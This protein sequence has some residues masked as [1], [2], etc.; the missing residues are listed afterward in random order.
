MKTN[1]KISIVLVIRRFFAVFVFFS[2]AFGIVDDFLSG[3]FTGDSV[4]GAIVGLVVVYFLSRTPKS[5]RTANKEDVI[6]EN[7]EK[8]E[9]IYDEETLEEFKQFDTESKNTIKDTQDKNS[10]NPV[11]DEDNFLAR[12]LKGRTDR[13]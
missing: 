10:Y 1:P 6:T 2:V 5:L 3:N 7:L 13:Y 9:D 11:K 12:M 8:D 4:S